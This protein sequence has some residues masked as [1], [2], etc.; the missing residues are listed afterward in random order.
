MKTLKEEIR[1]I[2][3]DNV[4]VVVDMNEDVN[5]KS[6]QDSMVELGLHNVFG[7]VNDVEEKNREA[8]YGHGSKCIDF[9]L[10]IEGVMKIVNMIELIECNEIVDSGHRGYLTDINLEA[11]F[12]E[13]INSSKEI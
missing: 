13:K 5:S 10:R 12:E 1:E 4:L 9:V 7:E 6:I 3:V 8:I 11:W 2:K